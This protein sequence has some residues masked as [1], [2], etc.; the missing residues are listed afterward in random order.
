MT[1]FIQYQPYPGKWSTFLTRSD[2][3]EAI[4][5]MNTRAFATGQQHRLIDEHGNLIQIIKP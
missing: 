1:L 5:M 3:E 2:L 4:L